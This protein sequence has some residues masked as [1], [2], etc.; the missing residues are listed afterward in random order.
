MGAGPAIVS[1]NDSYAG[2]IDTSR[3]WWKNGR[4]FAPIFPEDLVH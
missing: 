1:K 2:L 3:P 4:T